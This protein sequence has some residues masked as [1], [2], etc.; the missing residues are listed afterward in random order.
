MGRGEGVVGVVGH[1]KKN[2]LQLKAQRD[3]MDLLQEKR[4]D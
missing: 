4:R 3:V 2:K 1:E